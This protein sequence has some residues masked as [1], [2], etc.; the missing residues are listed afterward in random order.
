MDSIIIGVPA[1][2]VAVAPSI[3]ARSSEEEEE[4]KERSV[5]V[6]SSAATA[7]RSL[8]SAAVGLVTIISS[9]VITSASLWSEF[10]EIDPRRRD[11]FWSAVFCAT[12]TGEAV[13]AKMANAVANRTDSA[14]FL[15]EK[16]IM[17]LDAD[18]IVG[19]IGGLRCVALLEP[20]RETTIILVSTFWYCGNVIL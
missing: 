7:A 19:T 12:T 15:R 20:E 3:H 4:K 6:V 9:S 10:N 8:P 13:L 14:G 17:L 2:V 5:L 16:R 1:L 18:W 11:T